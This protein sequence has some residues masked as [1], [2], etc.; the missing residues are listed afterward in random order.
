MESHGYKN[1]AL[2]FEVLSSP[3]NRA[4]ISADLEINVAIIDELSR[5]VDLTRI[6][7][8]SPVTAKMLIFAGYGNVGSVARADPDK[9]CDEVD[10]VNKE[11]N[12]F[13]GKIGLRDIKRLVKA[14]SYV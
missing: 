13:K 8:V 12:F 5:V 11:N 6:Q 7:W 9:M 4:E 3:E 2:L 14:A 10:R 1:T